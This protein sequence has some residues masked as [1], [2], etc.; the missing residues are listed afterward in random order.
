MLTSNKTFFARKRLA[1][2]MPALLIGGALG[3]A[4][5]T[6]VASAQT[7]ESFRKTVDVPAGNLEDALNAFARQAGITL[8]FDPVL[9]QGKR[10]VALKGSYS[11]QEGLTRLLAGSQLVAQAAGD[12][13]YALRPAGAA[14]SDTVLKA[15]AVQSTA[16]FDAPPER[17]GFKADYQTSSTKSAMSIRETPQA[18]SVVTRE[19]LEARQVLD[20]NSALELVAGFNAAGKAFAGNNPRTGEEFILRGQTLDDSRDIRIDGFTA[21]GDRNNFDVAPFERI[22]VVKGPSSML[23]G[24]G[25]LGGFINLVRKKPQADP[26]IRVVAQAG[27]WDTYR[28]ELD[29][30][31]ALTQDKTVLSQVTLAYEDSGSFIDGVDLRRA[32]VAPSIEWLIDERNRVLFDVVYQDDRFRPSLGIALMPDGDEL[33]PPRVP[34]SFFFG[35]PNSED[36]TASALHS[37]VRFEHDLSDDWLAT[38]ML[39]SS[40]NRLLGISDSYG[41]GLDAEGNTS[42][43]S[44]YVDHDQ[45][46][47]AGELRLEGRFKAFGRD[48][49]LLVGAEKNKLDFD[50]GGGGGYPNIGYA[51]IYDGSLDHAPSVPGHSWP[52]NF[53][54]DS[55]GSSEAVYGQLLLSLLERTKLLLGVRYDQSE[56]S[57]LFNGESNT[58]DDKQ[59]DSDMTFRAG[60]VQDF[61]T[62]LT[63]YL[64]YAESFSPVQEMSRSGVLDPE[65]GEGYEAGLKG[66][67]FDG[68]LGATAAVFRQ[69]LDNRPI[70]DPSNGPNQS[71]QVSGGLQRTDGVELE[72]T[73]Q[74]LPGWT[75]S[76]AASWLD[77]EYIDN[78]DINVGKT[79]GGTIENQASL[80]TS[81][82]LQSG[83][84]KGFGVGATFISVGDRIV[85]TGNSSDENGAVL[86]GTNYSID[87]YERLDLQAF[88]T[89][90]DHWD[91]SLLVRNVTDEKYIER[92]N[93]AFLYGHFFGSPRAVMFRA[94]YEF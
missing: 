89:G 12:G 43:Y 20:I 55:D 48:H 27:S 2:I 29:A 84:L 38:L 65:T 77:A 47:W 22:E 37:T 8:S 67:W 19:S 86:P 74:P 53:E 56:S 45:L 18:I 42:L 88:Y 91:L 87:G 7:G 78:A 82:E 62:N 59:D 41:Y 40:R 30:G 52:R 35:V 57:F 79:P 92:T 49:Q 28:T 10:A 5:H 70:P 3:G 26:S 36:S 61:S 24:Q 66:E 33:R 90:L 93:S 58:G 34:R 68:R 63:G 6:P 4:T 75:I 15:V 17:H 14:G 85:L 31:G 9:V 81:Y 71:F 76:A 51:N 11:A 60:L 1:A 54:S 64:V 94:E 13:S 46:N 73:G 32:V 72:I 25:S 44:S 39:H 69:E 80:Y 16:T 21:G 83:A 50:V 23:Y